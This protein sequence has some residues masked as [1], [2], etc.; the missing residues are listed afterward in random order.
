MTREDIQKFSFFYFGI[1]CLYVENKSTVRTFKLRSFH[2]K[3]FSLRSK[4]QQFMSYSV[5][6][7]LS[8]L[9]E[10]KNKKT[11]NDEVAGLI[12]GLTQWVKDPALP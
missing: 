11:R 8:L 9:L 5:F 1:L 2:Q 7:F 6:I 4:G 12:P 3:C 10:N